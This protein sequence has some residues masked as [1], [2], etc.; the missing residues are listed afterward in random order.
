MTAGGIRAGFILAPATRQGMPP[1][2]LR[3]P[4]DGHYR[5]VTCTGGPKV[6]RRGEFHDE[7]C[8]SDKEGDYEEPPVDP[9]RQLRVAAAYLSQHHGCDY[10]ERNLFSEK[11]DH[12]AR[13]SRVEYLAQ[14]KSAIDRSLVDEVMQHLK[15]P[16]RFADRR[17]SA[18]HPATLVPFSLGHA[19][20]C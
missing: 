16:L 1:T 20:V 10:D 9:P 6:R 17:P 14:A 11:H 5:P 13:C 4:P 12:S 19:D 3:P 8:A 2:P 7:S 18:Q 15:L